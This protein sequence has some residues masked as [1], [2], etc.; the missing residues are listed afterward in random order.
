MDLERR[1]FIESAIAA[2]VAGVPL[3]A[4]A[5]PLDWPKNPVRFVVPLAPGGG[6]DGATRMVADRLRALWGIPTIVDNR[7]GG[8]TIIAAEAV[9]QAPRDG[10]TFMST[11]ALTMQLPYLMQKVPFDPMADLIPV[12]AITVEQ[13]V[14]VT[15]PAMGIKT[16]PELLKAA[17]RD[18][19]RYSFGSF[20]VGSS[21]HLVQI[22]ISKAA[23]ADLVHVPFSGATPA[24]Q[25]VLGGNV[26]CALSNLGTVKQHIDAGKLIPLAVTGERRYRLVPDVPTLAE[27]GFKGF[28]TPAWIGIFAAKGVPQPIVDKLSADLQTVL[29]TPELAANFNGFGQEVGL[30]SATEF[31]DLVVRD[32]ENASRMIRAA[33]IRL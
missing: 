6:I 26:A 31:R 29:K 10:Y 22:E 17:K 30:M 23:G 15:S 5:G 19:N 1:N 21:S 8:N 7:A 2:A 14:L 20:G 24:V 28:E 3:I 9:L 25:A 33:G 16:L 12:G 11:I 4:S 32:N 18:P 13:L 27:L